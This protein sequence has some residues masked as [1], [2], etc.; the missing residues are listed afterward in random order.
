MLSTRIH[1]L[2]NRFHP[3]LHTNKQRA[4]PESGYIR[5]G[6]IRYGVKMTVTANGTCA[7]LTPTVTAASVAAAAAASAAS[8][9]AA[10]PVRQTDSTYSSDVATNGTATVADYND[11]DDDDEDDCCCLGKS[12]A[13]KS[14]DCSIGGSNSFTNNN[15]INGS[16]ALAT[17]GCYLPMKSRLPAASTRMGK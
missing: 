15:H 14:N 3:P 16:A 7:P 10:H 4:I 9:A 8:N 12:P 5:L 11:H 6:S 17:D 2:P 13:Q 1:C